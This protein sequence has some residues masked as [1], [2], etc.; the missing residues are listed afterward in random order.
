M[1]GVG[2][3][4]VKENDF[5]DTPH[6]K[7]R[8]N[9]LIVQG[10]AILGFDKLYYTNTIPDKTFTILYYTYTNTIPTFWSGFQACNEYILHGK[11]PLKMKRGSK[12]FHIILNIS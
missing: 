1:Y 12:L 6:D 10:W 9:C 2:L 5:Q 4:E 7:R 3:T 11:T 8:N